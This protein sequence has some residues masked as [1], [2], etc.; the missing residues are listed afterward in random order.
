MAIRAGDARLCDV[1]RRRLAVLASIVP[2][3]LAAC[4][5]D[6]DAPSARVTDPTLPAD[7]PVTAAARPA[8]LAVPLCDDLPD[9]ADS[10]DWTGAQYADFPDPVLTA[11]A[12]TLAL[13]FP[14]VV[15]WWGGTDQREGWIV[16]GVSGGAVELQMML[17]SQFPGARVLAMPIAWTQIELRD[18]A[19]RLDEATLEL[20]LPAPSRV[21]MSRG[22]VQIDIDEITDDAVS[23][24]ER[25]EGEP[26]CVDGDFA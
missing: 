22:V 23:I 12:I 24:L 25:F 18:L 11:Q 21:S 19:T 13:G 5:G 10:L 7:P 2:L 8:G 4:S 14:F 3:T 20:A 6:D 9:P 17:D 16:V 15:E 1:I 26:V